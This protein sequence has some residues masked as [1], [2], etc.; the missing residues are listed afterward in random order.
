[1]AEEE[2]ITQDVD[3]TEDA[4]DQPDWQSF[5]DEDIRE[6][7]SLRDLGTI[8]DLAKRVIHSQ[9]LIGADKVVIPAA[10]AP[11]ED[12]S[13]FFKALGRP[14]TPDAYELPTENMPEGF[15]PADGRVDFMRTEAHR[16]GISAQQFAGLVRADANFMKKAGEDHATASA[17]THEESVLA[18]K[19]EM[20]AAYDQNVQIAKGTIERFADG[21]TAF[22]EFLNESKLG[23]DPR[24]VNMFV[25][26]GKM[27]SVD[28][29]IGEGGNK[30]DIPTPQEAQGK[31]DAMR[32]DPDFMTAYS[33]KKNPGF[34]AAQK[35]MQALYKLAHPEDAG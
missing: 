33:N 29:L 21:D 24:M 13:A 23:D 4:T 1:M 16:L 9:K 2:V 28:E 30:S 26:I 12:K 7:A 3:E 6:D 32:L 8:N 14:D 35:Q 17:Q 18:M 31:I 22:L 20:G 25:R 5:V 15:A 10:D 27:I 19:K 11:E 34:R